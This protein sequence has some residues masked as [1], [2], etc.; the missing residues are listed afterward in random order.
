MG[1]YIGYFHP[2]YTELH[3]EKRAAQALKRSPQQDLFEIFSP[4]QYTA[5]IT[6]AARSL[7]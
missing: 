6:P 5:K 7:L 2:Y 1:A 4:I 3:T